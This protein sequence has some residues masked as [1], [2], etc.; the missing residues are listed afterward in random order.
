MGNEPC[1]EEGAF[2]F[3]PVLEVFFERL[4]DGCILVIGVGRAPC[5]FGFMAT[6]TAGGEV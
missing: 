5:G 2:F 4:C 3:L 6:D 1:G